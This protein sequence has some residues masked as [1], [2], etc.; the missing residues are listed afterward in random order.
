MTGQSGLQV[1]LRPR[2]ATR[3]GGFIAPA[4]LR[5]ER[6]YG[7]V[8]IQY[9]RCDERVRAYRTAGVSARACRMTVISPNVRTYRLRW[10]CKPSPIPLDRSPQ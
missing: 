4:C 8:G 5:E 2:N 1:A 9:T 3:T 10:P 6:G 7:Q